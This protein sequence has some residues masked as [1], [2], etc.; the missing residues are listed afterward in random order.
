M[1]QIK[2]YSPSAKSIASGQVLKRPYSWEEGRLVVREM[3]DQVALDLAGKCY[4]AEGVTLYVGY[5]SFGRDGSLTYEGP[6]NLRFGKPRAASVHGTEKLPAPTASPSLITKA[7]LC[8]YDRLTDRRL[9][10]R[11]MSVAAIRLCPEEEYAPQLSLFRE[12][13][14]D[15]REKDLLRAVLHLHGRF[16]KNAV[17]KGHDLFDAATTVERNGQIGGHRK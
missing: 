16:G 11:R 15:L 5:E 14:N 7:V 2:A 10:V 3:A 1:E 13:Q 4:T 17:L 8:L 9:Q 6:V 12:E